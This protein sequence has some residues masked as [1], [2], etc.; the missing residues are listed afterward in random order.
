MSIAG[1]IGNTDIEMSVG[2]SPRLRRRASLTILD[3][4]RSTRRRSS[5]A[6]SISSFRS[7]ILQRVRRSSVGELELRTDYTVP[8]TDPRPEAYPTGMMA[9]APPPSYHVSANNNDGGGFPP[10]PSYDDVMNN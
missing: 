7:A 5:S 4:P 9:S 8:T 3:T 1:T 6:S 10:P 2:R